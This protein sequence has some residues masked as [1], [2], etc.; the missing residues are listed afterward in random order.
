MIASHICKDLYEWILSGEKQGT[1]HSIFNNS[2]NIIRG[3]RFISVV[4][5]N[6]PIS[7]NGIKIKDDMGFDDKNISI[8]E[9][10]VFTGNSFVATSFKI[11]YGDCVLWDK[12]IN[13]QYEKDNLE[14]VLHKI[15][16]LGGF[17]LQ[18]GNKNGIFNLLPLIMEE[19]GFENNIFN[20]KHILDKK[21]LFIIDRLLQF[22]DSFKNSKLEAI[23][24]NAKKIIGFGSGLTPSIDDFLSGMMIANIYISHYLGMNIENA[25]R[26]NSDIV[27]DIENKTTRVSEEMLKFSSLGQTNEH[28]RNLMIGLLSKMG[29]E[30]VHELFMSVASL[31]DSSGTD[32]LS[33]VYIGSL[34]LLNKI[35][36]EMHGC[37]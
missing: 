24:I 14:K 33:G 1:I 28:T 7:P 6:K 20:I 37:S 17:I 26:I 32:I 9:T 19:F 5:P 29:E 31:G 15:H 30:K 8:G 13:T 27:K 3:D 34:I 21:E 16:V 25:Y 18:H 10:G 4:A 11:D 2:I 36:G 22:V 12:N 35:R 23:N